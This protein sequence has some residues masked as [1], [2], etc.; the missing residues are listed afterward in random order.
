MVDRLQEIH[1]HLNRYHARMRWRREKGREPAG[2]VRQ[3][4]QDSPV[5]HAVDL[6]VQIEHRHGKHDP[7]TLGLPEPEAEVV[8]GVTVT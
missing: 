6:L 8:D 5:N 4:C 2:G 7:P 3:C 1:L